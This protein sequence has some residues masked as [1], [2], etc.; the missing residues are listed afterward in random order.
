MKIETDYKD[1]NKK[2]EFKS[3]KENKHL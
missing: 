1:V 3:S 2:K